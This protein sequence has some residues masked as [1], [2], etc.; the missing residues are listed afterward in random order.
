[1]ERAVWQVLLLAQQGEPDVTC[2]R[3][4]PID[5]LSVFMENIS[6]LPPPLQP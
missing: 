3:E 5:K 2:L 6:D 4:P 1:M